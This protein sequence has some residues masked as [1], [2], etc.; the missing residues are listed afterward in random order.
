MTVATGARKLLLLGLEQGIPGLQV[1]GPYALK[2]PNWGLRQAQLKDG[3]HHDRND[4]YYT[5][6]ELTGTLGE[7]EA[8]VISAS[9]PSDLDGELRTGLFVPV[10]ATFLGKPEVT[11]DGVHDAWMNEYPVT[12]DPGSA[13]SLWGMAHDGGSTTP[14]IF[15][16]KRYGDLELSGD[17]KT[18]ASFKA[19]G[20]G[21]GDTECGLGVPAIENTGTYLCAPVLSGNRG[22]VARYTDKLW[23]KVT[24]A[25]TL[26]VFKVKVALHATTPVYSSLETSIPYSTV[27]KKVTGWAELFGDAGALGIDSEK[28]CE[29]LLVFFPGDV[30][31]LALDDVFVFPALAVAPGTETGYTSVARTLLSGRT[32][33]PARVSLAKGASTADAPFLVEGWSLKLSRTLSPYQPGCGRNAMNPADIDV[34]GYVKSSLTFTRR[35]D[36]RVYQQAIRIG[37]RYAT[38]LDLDAG[39]LAGGTTYH[40]RVL[41][42]IAQ[43]RVQDAKVSTGGPGI[44]LE[45]ISLTG[46]Q[47]LSGADS[48]GLKVW[49]ATEWDFSVV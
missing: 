12:D 9:Y 33:A 6:P 18:T 44:K 14:I 41:A 22:D 40:E 3:I 16:G 24:S 35:Y 32:F 28:K 21:T 10:A 45:T 7:P 36:S 20:T 46:E 15:R 11:Q 17:G 30:T 39:M 13:V 49:S 27:S 23:V 37:D 29:P 1:G 31:T 8:T 38:Q 47:P 2:D 43:M 19:K 25:P 26:G 42:N 48:L 5:S 4:A 34:V